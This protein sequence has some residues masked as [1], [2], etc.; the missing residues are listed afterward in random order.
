[1]AKLKI[2]FSYLLALVA[3][4]FSTSVIADDEPTQ[5]GS[6]EEAAKKAGNAN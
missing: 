3:P 5:A 2:K 6:K 4:I 1:M